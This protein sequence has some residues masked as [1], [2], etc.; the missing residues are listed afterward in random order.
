[1]AKKNKVSSIGTVDCACVIHG[2]VYE[3]IYVDRLYNMLSRHFGDSVRFHV[4][5]EPERR[6]PSN[7]IKHELQ[8]WPGVSGAKRSWWYKMQL[9]NEQ[10][11]QGPLLYIDLD[12][13]IFNSMQWAREV[14]LDYFWALRDFRYL[15]NPAYNKMN[16]SVM[17]WDTR[18]F[19]YL[20]EKLK[21]DCIENVISQYPGDQ[22]Y[23]YANIDRSL[24]RYYDSDRVQSYR[25]Q[26]MDGGM[27]FSAR[28]NAKP[29]TGIKL[30]N[31]A[32]MLVFHG[33]PKPHEVKDPVVIKHWC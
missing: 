15:Q 5:T 6:V 17:Y 18:R 31:Q 27:N 13:V 16:S 4:F 9:F 1:M 22:D 29:G 32:S 8:I 7:M 25:W 10:H 14:S 26:A 11:W 19:G 28:K 24:L 21:N 2:I 3:W 33:R 20:W 12:V 23:I 30:D